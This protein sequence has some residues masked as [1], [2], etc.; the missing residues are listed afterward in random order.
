MK[1]DENN[2]MIINSVLLYI[3]NYF[4]LDASETNK[5]ITNLYIITFEIPNMIKKKT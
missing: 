4:A 1:C 5:S 2:A 3:F